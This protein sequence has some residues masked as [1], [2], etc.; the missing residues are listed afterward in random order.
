MKTLHL[1]LKKKWFDM[2]LFGGKKEEYRSLNEYWIRRLIQ[3]DRETDFDVLDE[4]VTDIQNPYERHVS[5]VDMLDYFQCRFIDFDT[6][7]FSNGY[8]KNRRQFVI[9]LKEIRI[10]IGNPKWGADE[11]QKYFVLE[12]G[13]IISVENCEYDGVEKWKITIEDGQFSDFWKSEIMSYKEGDIIYDNLDEGGDDFP[14]GYVLN[15][16]YKTK[17]VFCI[18]VFTGEFPTDEKEHIELKNA[19][20]GFYE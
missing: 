10:G 7:T 8:A 5:V 19:M 11:H 18:G 20:A 16:D 9:E 15:I 6:I 1:N 14:K 17:S 13:D 12:L 3:F 2:I 4:L